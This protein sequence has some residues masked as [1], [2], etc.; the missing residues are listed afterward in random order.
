M[1]NKNEWKKCLKVAKETKVWAGLRIVQQIHLQR[2]P[3]I[4]PSK[5][6]SSF[7]MV[8]FSKLEFN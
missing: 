6:C 3:A 7:K 2:I 4:L 5:L 1:Q 8:A